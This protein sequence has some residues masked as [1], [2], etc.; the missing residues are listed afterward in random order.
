MGRNTHNSG[1]VLFSRILNNTSCI[2]NINSEETGDSS[3][4]PGDEESDTASSES[5]S[6]KYI[7]SHTTK[8]SD[9]DP[10]SPPGRTSSP[11]KLRRKHMPRDDDDSSSGSS[12]STLTEKRSNKNKKK[13]KKPKKLPTDGLGDVSTEETITPRTDDD[14][15]S[16]RGKGE[17]EKPEASKKPRRRDFDSLAVSKYAPA[18]N[19]LPSCSAVKVPPQ[20]TATFAHAE[21][22]V[23][24]FFSQVAH[25]SPL[26]PPHPS[27]PPSL[28]YFRYFHFNLILFLI[29][30]FSPIRA[31]A[32][33]A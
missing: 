7:K 29:H 31:Q 2:D 22:I 23:D 28:N 8:T 18:K 20:Y 3:S 19:V 15:D 16:P 9:A 27:H 6:S 5:G 25:V 11:S 26:S 14:L 10:M 4:T 17:K 32:V 13:T 30:F 21:G 33:A 24:K 1:E 12:S